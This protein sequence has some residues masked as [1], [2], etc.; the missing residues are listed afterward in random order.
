MSAALDPACSTVIS[1][2]VPRTTVCL[3]SWFATRTMY[4]LCPFCE[5]FRAKAGR[6]RSM[7]VRPV[8]PILRSRKVR[9]TVRSLRVAWMRMVCSVVCYLDRRSFEGN[10]AAAVNRQRAPRGETRPKAVS[11]LAAC[12]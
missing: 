12:G 1:S 11:G 2:V 6:S 9:R 8:R 10:K 7:T 5:T 3:P 4:F